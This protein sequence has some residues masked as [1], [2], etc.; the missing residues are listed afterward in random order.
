MAR[1]RAG[2]CFGGNRDPDVVGGS[3]LL[4][5]ERTKDDIGAL[6]CQ[7]VRRSDVTGLGIS[8]RRVVLNHPE[9]RIGQCPIDRMQPDRIEHRRPRSRGR[10]APV[11]IERVRMITVMGRDLGAGLTQHDLRREGGIGDQDH[12]RASAMIEVVSSEPAS[13]GSM[14]SRRDR[15]SS[16]TPSS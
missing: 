3:P 11:L 9:R 4:P 10:L 8:Q 13:I 7:P 2:S 15:G 5:V 12:R 1:H 14:G 16:T 6:A